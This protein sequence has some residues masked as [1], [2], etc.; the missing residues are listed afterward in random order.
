MTHAPEMLTRAELLAFA[1]V[2]DDT[3]TDDQFDRWRKRGLL[4]SPQRRGR[5]QGLGTEALYPASAGPQLVAVAEAIRLHGSVDD[6]LWH[7][8]WDGAQ[9]ED[10]RIV[11]LLGKEL[12]RHEDFR[13]R[14]VTMFAPDQNTDD[15]STDAE[16]AQ[17]ERRVRGRMTD[18]ALARYRRRVGMDEYTTLSM[19]V[20]QLLSGTYES[21]DP[22]DLNRVNKSWGGLTPTDHLGI[23]RAL[24]TLAAPQSLKA[25]IS[26]LRDN[27]LFEAREQGRLLLAR[28]AEAFDLK[29]ED[30]GTVYDAP[31]PN[32]PPELRALLTV[33][34]SPWVFLLWLSARQQPL[35]NLAKPIL[36][37]LLNNPITQ[38]RSLDFDAL[39]S[40]ETE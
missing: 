35:F 7:L 32:F 40:R 28:L 11:A 23:V 12:L 27:E 15:A 25:G 1:R 3:I 26:A 20:L 8:W 9:I 38:W 36:V 33:A 18:S 37:K 30:A 34:P 22:A 21:H 39:P 10:R 29:A 14:L 13:L 4:P 17:L 24:S 19:W 31:P 6:A 16:Y 2:Y 5:G